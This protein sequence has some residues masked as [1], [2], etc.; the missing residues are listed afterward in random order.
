MHDALKCDIS[1]LVT[2]RKNLE[3]IEIQL[4]SHLTIKSSAHSCLA[5]NGQIVL[6]HNF[7]GIPMKRSSARN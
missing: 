6:I 1:K 3:I 2:Y 7:C 5:M 4:K